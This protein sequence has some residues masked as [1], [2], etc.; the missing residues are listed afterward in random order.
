MISS[1]NLKKSYI[2]EARNLPLATWSLALWSL[3][4]ISFKLFFTFW[5][6][7]LDGLLSC[8]SLP[9]AITTR[10]RLYQPASNFRLT[11]RTKIHNQATHRDHKTDSLLLLFTSVQ[12]VSLACSSVGLRPHQPPNS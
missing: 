2:T 1:R 8:T 7:F 9:R 10:G 11:T 6:E 12:S 4:L 5:L 3:K